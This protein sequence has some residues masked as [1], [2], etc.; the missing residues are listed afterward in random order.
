[1]NLFIPHQTVGLIV[2]RLSFYEDVFGIE[3]THRDFYVIKQRN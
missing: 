1:M 3:I 2:L